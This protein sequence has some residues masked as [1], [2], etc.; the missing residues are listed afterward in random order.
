LQLNNG[1]NLAYQE[2]IS[3]GIIHEYV[4]D[5][6]IL[7]NNTFIRFNQKV[8]F[9]YI[10]FEK[11]R[12][13]RELNAD[14]FFEI[15]DF[16]ISNIQLQCNILNFFTS[17]LIQK[18]RFDIIKQIHTEIEKK[19]PPINAHVQ[20]PPYLSSVSVKINDSFLTNTRFREEMIPW[21]SSSNLGKILY[22]HY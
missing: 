12:T 4:V 2:L 16:Y 17:A 9:E 7:D 22:P 1:N 14:L 6:S 19:I 13:N 15:S 5:K 8:I 10:L 21:I 3:H 11:W 18:S 20:I